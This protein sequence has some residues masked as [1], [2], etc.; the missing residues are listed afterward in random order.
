M[1]KID[2]IISILTYP[3]HIFAAVYVII[4]YLIKSLILRIPVSYPGNPIP[5]PQV[6]KGKWPKKTSTMSPGWLFA[7]DTKSHDISQR[8]TNVPLDGE[9]AGRQ[10]WYKKKEDT[11]RGSINFFSSPTD[12]PASP[13]GSRKSFLEPLTFSATE[14]P[15]AGDK[16]FRNAMIQAWS[17]DVPDEDFK[18]ATARESAAKGLAFYQ[19]LQCDDGHWAGDYGGPMFLMPGLII[20][21]Y[22]TKTPYPAGRREG[23]I[24]YLL[25]HQQED[26]GWGTHI[27]CASTMFGTILSYISLRLLGEPETSPQLRLAHEF[28]MQYGGALYA[29][30]WAKFWM[31][32]L[33]KPIRSLPQL[34]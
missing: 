25:N 2:W 7:C 33:G 4:E 3:R 5:N 12:T 21:M 26:G 6:R 15:N 13:R 10:I 14:N 18:P 17:G 16:V 8:N 27:E 1:Q 29:P 34:F 9:S 11:T 30:S 19:M 22:I 28:L 24:Q 32:V 31:A 23:M 20:V